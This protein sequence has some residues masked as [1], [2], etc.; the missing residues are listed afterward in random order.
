MTTA[1]SLN[2]SN[3]KK[4]NESCWTYLR[5]WESGAALAG[6]LTRRILVVTP[7]AERSDRPVSRRLCC[8]K[9]RSCPLSERASLPILPER[10][11][12]GVEVGVAVDADA[13]VVAGD[14]SLGRSTSAE[15]GEK[16]WSGERALIRG[17]LTE[18]LI[19]RGRSMVEL[20]RRRGG[21]VTG[22]GGLGLRERDKDWC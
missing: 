16:V 5:S 17:R 14:P 15:S 22:E 18:E 11:R 12:L 9:T 6:A 1:I 3:T 10:E 2:V 7:S 20:C 4:G 19:L 21:G 13:D 8:V